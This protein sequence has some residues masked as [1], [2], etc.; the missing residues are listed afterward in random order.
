MVTCLAPQILLASSA[1]VGGVE[2]I[3][4][5]LGL[6][7][8]NIAPVW[9]Q[10]C[11]QENLFEKFTEWHTGGP[12]HHSVGSTYHSL[13]LVCSQLC[14]IISCKCTHLVIILLALK[15]MCYCTDSIQM[16]CPFKPTSVYVHLVMFI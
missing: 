9:Y 5:V 6:V 10:C 1:S 15:M 8:H 3:I 11:C 7:R 14:L 2:M 16:R 13:L 12:V 4:Q